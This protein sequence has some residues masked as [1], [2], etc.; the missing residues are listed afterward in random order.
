MKTGATTVSKTRVLAIAITTVLGGLLLIVPASLG[1]DAGK[2]VTCGMTVTSYVKLNQDLSCTGNGLVVGANGVTIDLNGYTLAGSGGARPFLGVIVNGWAHVTIR[3]GTVTQFR[4]GI[5]I[6]N[7]NDVMMKGLAVVGNGLVGFASSDGIRVFSSSQVQ[8]E[9][10]VLASNADDSVEIQG[11]TGVSVSENTIRASGAGIAFTTVPSSDVSVRKNWIV[12]N[13]CGIK[14]T[15][16][17][18]TFERNVFERNGT[19][20]CA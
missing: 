13:A 5:S 15:T 17:G 1:T 2:A 20:F 4:T 3:G 7:S 16:T 9:K 8:V 18:V 6:T 19:D 12:E 14:G 10:S 11:S